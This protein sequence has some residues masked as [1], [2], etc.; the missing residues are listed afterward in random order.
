M[1]G[2][3]Y[4]GARLK[5]LDNGATDG[6]PVTKALTIEDANANV[7]FKVKAAAPGT[8]TGGIGPSPGARTI[9][10]RLLEKQGWPSG[11][12]TAHIKL[13][14]NQLG[15]LRLFNTYN[16]IDDAFGTYQE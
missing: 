5:A 3:I 16:K 2:S 1:T 6:N 4:T 14:G 15:S 12:D 9:N 11:Y 7:T 10:N 13:I 8:G